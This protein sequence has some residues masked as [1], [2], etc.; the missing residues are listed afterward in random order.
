MEERFDIPGLL[1]LRKVTRI[2]SEELSR[3][4]KEHLSVLAPLFNPKVILGKHVRGGPQAASKAADKAFEEIQQ[5]YQS[6]CSSKPFNL[7]KSFD[8]SLELMSTSPEATASEY[9]YAAES[10]EGRKSL[11]ITS[12]LKWILTCKGYGPPAVPRAARPSERSYWS[13][14]QTLVLHQLSNSKWLNLH[15]RQL[16]H[17]RPP[18]S[19]GSSPLL[20]TR[21]LCTN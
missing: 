8:S 4:R 15:S 5:L 3:Q 17:Q 13:G 20:R 7:R 14:A 16:S 9:R 10:G 1:A 21:A 12:P 6:M 18:P 2:I 19:A 11:I